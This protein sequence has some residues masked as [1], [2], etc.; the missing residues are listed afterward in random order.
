[1]TYFIDFDLSKKNGRIK[2]TIVQILWIQ[3]FAEQ[4]FFTE[5]IFVFY[6]PFREIKFR[7]IY[8]LLLDS[9]NTRV[10]N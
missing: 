10:S 4:I 2:Y 9:E 3:I 7:E 1:M 6:G 8:Q 5:L